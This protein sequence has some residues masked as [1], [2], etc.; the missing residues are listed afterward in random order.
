MEL[1]EVFKFEMRAE[2]TAN[3]SLSYLHYRPGMEVVTHLGA[4]FHGVLLPPRTVKRLSVP[5]RIPEHTNLREAY[6]MMPESATTLP[7]R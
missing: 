1:E 3:W 4:P 5:S 7:M 2:M 6:A